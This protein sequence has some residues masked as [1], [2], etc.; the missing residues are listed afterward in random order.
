MY[1]HVIEEGD[2]GSVA[3]HGWYENY[4]EACLER[5]RLQRFYPDLF[6]YVYG[7]DS[8]DEPVFVTI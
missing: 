1:Y 5:D 3:S 8:S 2:Y 7:S 6:F 4:H